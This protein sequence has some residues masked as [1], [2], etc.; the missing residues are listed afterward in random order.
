MVP[1]LFL[2][3]CSG[4]PTVTV[5]TQAHPEAPAPKVLATA[6]ETDFQRPIQRC[7]TEALE[8][9]SDL[10]GTV[11]LQVYGSHGILKQTVESPAPLALIACAKEPLN[12]S[13][14]QRKYGDGPVEVGFFLNV[15]FGD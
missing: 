1:L 5:T 11:S 15:V 9:Q 8:T 7:Y 3:A 2:V 14:R 6:L 4:E 10:K 13:K 12:D